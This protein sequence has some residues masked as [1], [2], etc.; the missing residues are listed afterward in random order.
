MKDFLRKISLFSE[1]GDEELDFIVKVASQKEYPKG[2]RIIHKDDPGL[3]LFLVRLGEVKVILEEPPGEEIH[4]STLRKHEFFGEMALFSGKSRSATVVAQENSTIVEIS[5][6]IFMSQISKHPEISL[7][8]AG[9]MAERLRRSDLVVKEYAS[10]IFNEVYPKLEKTLAGELDTVRAVYQR[11][12]DRASKT[13]DEVERSWRTLTRVIYIIIGVFTFLGSIIGGTL[14]YIGYEKYTSIAHKYTQIE[15]KYTKIERI[16]SSA[17]E[18]EKKIKIVKV[19]AD[20]V[21]VIRE[22]LLNIQNIKNELLTN[23]DVKQLN[24]HEL[25]NKAVNF[26]IYKRDLFNNYI[27]NH[28]NHHPDIVLESIDTFMELIEKGQVHLEPKETDSLV[29][30]TLH[31]L[32]KSIEKDWRM[33]LKA[34]EIFLELADQV[35]KEKYGEKYQELLTQLEVLI[36]D[37]KLQDHVRFNIAILLASLGAQDEKGIAI[38]EEIMNEKKN[39]WRSSLAALHLIKIGKKQGWKYMTET[40]FR[41]DRASFVAA[42]LLSELGKEELQNLGVEQL[43]AGKNIDPYVLINDCIQNGLSENANVFMRE[44]TKV[45]G[46]ELTHSQ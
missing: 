46:K 20:K 27:K 11:T 36:R 18:A 21:N 1:L 15:K 9:V 33:Q 2:S 16:Y 37:R 23:P 10:K 8:I 17:I 34:R 19:A 29:Q 13:V 42:F 38:L 25:K 31:V 44:Y 28:D 5:R 39:P 43:V 14:T 40:I 6:E 35:Q 3:S 41:K 32:K 12:E 45:I 22:V 4:L 30:A 26:I 24:K 7:K